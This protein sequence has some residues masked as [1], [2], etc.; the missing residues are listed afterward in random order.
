M[1]TAWNTATASYNAWSKGSASKLW[2]F[3]QIPGALPTA[4]ASQD[5]GG[6]RKRDRQEHEQAQPASSKSCFGLPKRCC[7][8]AFEVGHSL[9]ES[10]SNPQDI[11]TLYKMPIHMK[12]IETA[13]GESLISSAN[14]QPALPELL[15]LRRTLKIDSC[16]RRDSTSIR[17]RRLMLQ[18]LIGQGP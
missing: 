1:L 18:G 16:T 11:R 10:L 9:Q 7:H 15:C 13:G 6:R 3:G 2:C 5:V 14:F 12:L 8:R 4:Q 17:L